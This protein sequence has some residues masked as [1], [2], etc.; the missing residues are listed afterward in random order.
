MANK[1]VVDNTWYL[2]KNPSAAQVAK[3]V[4]KSL[5]KKTALGTV[6]LGAVLGL[7]DGLN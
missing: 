1:K 7:Q 3:G 5:L 2:L 6:T 4:G